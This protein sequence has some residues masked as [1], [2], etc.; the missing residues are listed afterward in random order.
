M[1]CEAWGK[2]VSDGN[3]EKLF[4]YNIFNNAHYNV[5]LNAPLKKLNIKIS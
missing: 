4:Q 3:F 5:I 1:L 2:F